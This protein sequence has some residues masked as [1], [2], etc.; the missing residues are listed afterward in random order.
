MIEM[1]THTIS[2]N[3]DTTDNNTWHEVVSLCD[4][5]EALYNVSYF[6]EHYHTNKY[7][8]SHND[9]ILN[10]NSRYGVCTICRLHKY[11]VI[12]HHSCHTCM[13]T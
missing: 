10:I 9:T 8:I 5:S 7:R 11:I 2:V 1:S 12:G 3:F 13:R 6:V 4:E